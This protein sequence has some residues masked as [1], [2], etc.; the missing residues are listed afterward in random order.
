M[1]S[2]STI[3]VPPSLTKRHW[4]KNPP[5]ESVYISRPVAVVP[6]G[7]ADLLNVQPKIKDRVSLGQYL[8]VLGVS[9]PG[10]PMASRPNGRGRTRTIHP[11]YTYQHRSDGVVVVLKIWLAAIHRDPGA[12]MCLSL[13]PV[14]G[15]AFRAG[16]RAIDID[17]PV[18]R[19]RVRP[20][21]ARRRVAAGSCVCCS[22]AP[23]RAERSDR[24]DGLDPGR[25]PRHPSNAERPRR[26][27]ARQ[28]PRSTR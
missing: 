24:H 23:R 10:K 2:L 8:P 17:R 5:A 3:R 9:S 13:V 16:L 11:R 18:G 26:R 22:S 7:S 28:D 21:H 12:R 1:R 25:D 20:R 19:K 4:A 6:N 27:L 15:G 14:G